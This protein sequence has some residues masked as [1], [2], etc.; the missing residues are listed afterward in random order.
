MRFAPWRDRSPPSALPTCDYLAMLSPALKLRPPVI[1]SYLLIRGLALSSLLVAGCHCHMPT[2]HTEVNAEGHMLNEAATPGNSGPVHPFNV[3]AA[4]GDSCGPVV[5]VIDIDGLLLDMDMTGPGSAGE[6]PVSLF[7]ERLDAAAADP[8][9][10]AVVVRIN[11][12]GGG[13]AASDM[14]RR[15]LEQFKNRTHLPVVASLLGTATGGAYY[16]ATAAD[17]IIALPTTVTG[18]IGV[19]LNLYNLEKTIEQYNIGPATVKSGQFIDSGTPLRTATDPE[20]AHL[21]SIARLFHQRFKEVVLQSR[22]TIQSVPS[23]PRIDATAKEL[24]EQL[25]RTPTESELAERL[26]TSPLEL[27]KSMI[28]EGQIYTGAQ[29]VQL[30]LVDS[31][32]YPDDAVAAG[33]GMAGLARAQVVLYHRCNDRAR[34]VYSTTANVPLQGETTVLNLPGLARSR[35]PTFLYLWEPEPTME[36]LSGR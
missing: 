13:V 7:R 6:N 29:A 1:H 27:A 25:G 4:N 32:G 26:Q 2:I 19:I 28:F 5:A 9:V 8:C 11:S 31:L 21:E 33:C 36:K 22:P 35:M 10:K 17:Q 24:S 12:Y 34:S 18:G 3:P 23:D 15:D 30:H 20:R 14:M 16:I